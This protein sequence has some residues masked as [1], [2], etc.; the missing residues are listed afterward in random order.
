MLDIDDYVYLNEKENLNISVI[1]QEGEKYNMAIASV[2]LE[3][4]DIPGEEEN[5]IEDESGGSLRFAFIG[6]GQCGGRIAEA[7]YNI[8]YKKTFI[9][10]TAQ[11]D[12]DKNSVPNKMLIQ[13]SGRSGGA[14]KDMKL[15]ELTVKSEKDSIYNKMCDLFGNIDHIFVCAGLGGG[16]G[17]G[18]ITTIL[19][20]AKKYMEY[21]DVPDAAKKV[22]AIITLPTQGETSSPLVANNAYEKSNQLSDLADSENITPLIIIDNDKVK[23]L[24]KNLTVAKFFPTINNSVAQL[25]HVFNTIALEPSEYITF[26]TTDFQ[27]IL[28]VGGHMIMGVSTVRNFESKIS[29]SEALKKNLSKTLLASGFD[30]EKAKAVACI[31]VGGND[32]FNEV[33]GLMDNIEY[34][35]D[36]I[37]QFTGNAKVHRGIYAD[38][39]RQGR[40]NVFTIIS[41]LEKPSE[42]YE[43]MKPVSIKRKK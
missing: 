4:F 7:F 41:G 27:S 1:N 22:G 36:T 19:E 39:N 8:G 23:Q 29:I 35:F 26:D 17:G 5:T 15:A 43:K 3:E 28:E 33:E 11:Q 25:L 2:E 34:G 24:Y 14:G 16:T 18:S 6:T 20:T 10:N 30:L 13:L 9:I 12:L 32:I 37:A 42:R 21:I 31:V 40:I 38:E